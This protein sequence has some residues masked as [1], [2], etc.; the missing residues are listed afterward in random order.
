MGA[1]HPEVAEAKQS[2]ALAHILK[3]EYDEAEEMLAGAWE[4]VQHA[5]G[6]AHPKA[7][8]C[9]DR[10]GTLASAKGQLCEAKELHLRSL[11]V[12]KA[13]LGES[14]PE[15]ADVLASLSAAQ[16]ELGEREAAASSLST[17]LA[18]IYATYGEEHYKFKDAVQ[19]LLAMGFD[20]P[21]LTSG[22]EGDLSLIVDVG[23]WKSIRG[24][25]DVSGSGRRQADKK[26]AVDPATISAMQM[27]GFA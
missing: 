16:E 15:V 10:M 19:Q 8:Y 11:A 14:H 6:T 12:L 9:L 4:I 2:M 27:L 21:E 22:P 13:S 17:A 3:A 26:L 24:G 20:P 18:I 5:F 23:S 1:N 25:S 7:G